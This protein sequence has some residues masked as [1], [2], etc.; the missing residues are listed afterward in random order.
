MS[1]LYVRRYSLSDGA[2][3]FPWFYLAY[4]KK[5][6]NQHFT[7]HQLV[8]LRMQSTMLSRA[9]CS[10]TQSSGC[11]MPAHL[12]GH[13]RLNSEEHERPEHR[14]RRSVVIDLI[15]LPYQHSVQEIDA[16]RTQTPSSSDSAPASGG[17]ACCCSPRSTSRPVRS[18]QGS[19]SLIALTII[20]SVAYRD[21]GS[22]EDQ[23]IRTYL[24]INNYPSQG[25][26]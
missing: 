2:W 23:H 10:L 15:I 16:V 12:L 25:L 20:P 21:L 14:R 13:Q 8:E 11:R 22:P 24:T 18:P 4:C 19:A 6:E 3:G 1:Y 5:P 17:R 9:L 26:E 7:R